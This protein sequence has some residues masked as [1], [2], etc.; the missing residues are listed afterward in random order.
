MDRAIL[1]V[2]D[3]VEDKRYIENILREAGFTNLSFAPNY[4]KALKVLESQCFDVVLIDINLNDNQ[5][6]IA[7][8]QTIDSE[9]CLPYIFI[10]GYH[11]EN[12][13]ITK[14]IA[15]LQYK[16]YISKPIDKETFLVNLN[17]A[18]D[19]F[20]DAIEIAPDTQ[21]NFKEKTLK[22]KN[23]TFTLPEKPTRLLTILTNNINRLVNLETIYN[24]VWPK[25]R[26]T[27]ASS[28]RELKS[29]LIK[30]LKK[31]GVNANIETKNGEGLK[32]TF[33]KDSFKKR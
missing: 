23:K 29:S 33:Q 21:F 10:S 12:S 9:F 20:K 26:P 22:I 6:G 27:A 5:D 32:L 1:V 18:L 31:Y 16:N 3:S 7:L 25:D 8:A 19:I 30:Q 11:Q 24:F 13:S 2:E 17:V 15:S 14:Q 4:K 28:L